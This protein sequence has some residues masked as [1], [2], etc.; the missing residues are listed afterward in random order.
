MLCY[1]ATWAN[2]WTEAT[3]QTEHF[4]GNDWQVIDT[5]E[6]TTRLM[7]NHASAGDSDQPL[8]LQP[9]RSVRS[10]ESHTL[11]NDP[12]AS[13]QWSFLPTDSQPGSAGLFSARIHNANIHEV[14]V[15]IVDSG[16]LQDHEDLSTLPGYDFVSNPSIGNDGDGRDADPTDPGDWVNLEDHE[17]NRVNPNC[18]I[19]GS[20]WHG[21]AIAGIIGARSSNA[22]GIAGGASGAALLPV[23]VTGKCG[24]LI[25][26][27]VDGIRWAAGLPVSGAPANTNPARVINLSVGF[28]GNCP[29]ALQNAIN[30]AVNAGAIVVAAATNSGVNLDQ[31]PYSPATCNNLLSIG[32]SVRNGNLADYSARGSAVFMLAPGGTVTDGIIT[33]G[34]SG[35]AGPLPDSSYHLHFGTSLAAAHA[36][37]TLVTLLAIDPTLDNRELQNYLQESAIPVTDTRCTGLQCGHGRLNADR[38]VKMLLNEPVEL[39]LPQ[40]APALATNEPATG[41]VDTLSLTGL[42]LLLLGRMAVTKN[43]QLN[44]NGCTKKMFVKKTPS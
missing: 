8:Y 17:L 7:G 32:A 22:L 24:G 42:L 43:R 1:T 41:P 4:A 37:A 28:A 5:L 11:P 6:A 12:Y 9:K 10:S 30:D 21:T 44:F 27:L 19:S 38:A 29:A 33:S 3:L 18:E 34:N 40:A 31:Q 2:Q 26:D 13:T 35:T 36:S 20:S 39:L 16:T 23:R 25:A 14:V 15:A